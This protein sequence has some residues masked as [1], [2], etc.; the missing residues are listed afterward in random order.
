MAVVVLTPEA[1]GSSSEG[2]REVVSFGR[3]DCNSAGLN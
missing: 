2:G 1:P 3:S